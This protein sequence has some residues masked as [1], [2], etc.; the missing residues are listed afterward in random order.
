MVSL[1]E[2]RKGKRP[3]K[4]E[5]RPLYVPEGDCLTFYF[6]DDEA[7]AERVDELLTVYRS[8]KSDELVGC[9]IKGV[10][11]ILKNL[12]NFGVQVKDGSI[13][14]RALFIAYAFATK[15]WPPAKTFG[16]LREAAEKAKARFAVGDLIPA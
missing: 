1:D 7:Y 9:Q 5:A 3:G 13:D 11:F 4:F 15:Q 16:E 2:Y 6:K 10:R 8:M 14:L 12:G